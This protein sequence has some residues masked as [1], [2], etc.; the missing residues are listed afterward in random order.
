MGPITPAHCPSLTLLTTVFLHEL[1]ASK[2]ITNLELLHEVERESR[3][4][5]RF[6]F[7]RLTQIGSVP[8]LSGFVEVQGIL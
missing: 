3:T 8:Q 7:G 5:L 2:E 6:D 1:K 4:L